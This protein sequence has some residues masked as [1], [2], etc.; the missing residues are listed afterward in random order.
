MHLSRL[1][2]KNYRSISELDLNFSKGKNI[3]VGRNNAGKSNIFK[4]LNI[5]LGENSPTYEK[6]S[7]I[8]E[9]DFYSWKE[10]NGEEVF[11]QNSNELFIWC[12][13]NRD[14]EESLNYEEIYK[15]YGFNKMITR[16]SRQKLPKDYNHIF[17]FNEDELDRQN[18][19]YVNPKLKH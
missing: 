11:V 13:L 7:N 2:I 14:T 5:V 18:K 12:E 4:A 9:I 17:E 15:C 3:I 16:L 10:V 6:S 19:L 1:Y 8:T